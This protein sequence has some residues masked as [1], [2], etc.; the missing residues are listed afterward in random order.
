MHFSKSSRVILNRRTTLNLSQVWFSSH[1]YATKCSS[2]RSWSML[3]H[4]GIPYRILGSISCE[5]RHVRCSVSQLNVRLHNVMGW[6]ELKATHEA[7]SGRRLH[8]TNHHG[9]IWTRKQID[10]EVIYAKDSPLG[11]I[12]RQTH[13]WLRGHSTYQRKSIRAS[14]FSQF[15]DRVSHYQASLRAFFYKVWKKKK[16]GWG[17]GRKCHW[18][19]ILEEEKNKLLPNSFSLSDT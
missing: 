11:R 2:P 6:A 9:R 15:R 19:Q 13:A 16:K 5:H 12:L 1:C 8:V 14:H 3:S 4:L 17:G 7:G 10:L 18:R